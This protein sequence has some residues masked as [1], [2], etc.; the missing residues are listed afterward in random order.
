[1]IVDRF[2]MGEGLLYDVGCGD[3]RDTLYLNTFVR[4]CGLDSSEVVIEGNKD[5]FMGIAFHHGDLSSFDYGGSYS[6]YARFVLHA[7]DYESEA[8][9]FSNMSG[10]ERLF[11][12]CRTINDD[13]YG[14]GEEVGPHEFVNGH[15]RRFIDPMVLEQQLKDAGFQIWMFQEST[16]F[17]VTPTEDP[18]LLRVAALRT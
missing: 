18:P 11:I 4:C 13:R 14:E 3:A 8:R 9:W 17:S 7:I 2:D 6:I 1:V 12:E 15:Y 16:G 10:C 5:R